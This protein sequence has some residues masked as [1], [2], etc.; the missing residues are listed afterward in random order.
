MTSLIGTLVV[1]LVVGLLA[2]VI[3]PGGDKLGWIMTMLVGVTGSL[4]ATY[5]GLAVGWYEHGEAAG[6]L[7]SVGGAIAL[8]AVFS[9]VK[10]KP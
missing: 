5:V 7:A 9:H 3:T 6:W 1:G 10:G 2:R 8:L 4:L